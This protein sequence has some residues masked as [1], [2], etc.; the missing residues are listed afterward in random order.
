MA[1]L[2]HTHAALIVL[3]VLVV[4]DATCVIGQLL[5]DIFIVKENLEKTEIEKH[6]LAITL[7]SMFPKF[8]NNTENLSLNEMLGQLK[9]TLEVE[10]ILDNYTQYRQINR[11]DLDPGRSTTALLLN[12]TEVAPQ[13]AKKLPPNSTSAD[14]KSENQN[15]DPSVLDT[16]Q[17]EFLLAW[18][19]LT[20]SLKEDENI[21]K[22]ITGSRTS[23]LG[24]VDEQSGNSSRSKVKES[25]LNKKSSRKTGTKDKGDL[26]KE[27]DI[28]LEVTHVFH[29]ASLSILSILLFETLLKIFAMGRKLWNHKLEVFDA[30][31]II[32]SWS[33]DLAFKDG[34]WDHP[35][36]NAATILI[37]LLPWRVVRIVN[38]FVLVIQEKDN[39]RLKL[40]K[41]RYRSSERRTREYKEKLNKYRVET[42]SLQG[43][44]RKFGVPEGQITACMPIE[45]RK[46]SSLA[47]TAL[48]EFASLAMVSTVGSLPNLASKSE[49]SSDSS[50]S[51]DEES[52]DQHRE[53]DRTVSADSAFSQTD[54]IFSTVSF[55]VDCPNNLGEEN[56]AYIHETLDN[57][58]SLPTYEDAMISVYNSKP[59]E[60]QSQNQH[61]KL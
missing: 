1:K 51:D 36:S 22:L 58:G 38:S 26:E 14:R 60:I 35:G 42:K 29:L 7:Q 8:F 17:D 37:I 13:V 18:K 32:T 4:L 52:S 24:S 5:A 40:I 30:G 6:D 48:S 21:L 11:G 23:Y 45:K 39:V 10:K 31:V 34:I 55:A 53:I 33:L 41:Q 16:E 19:Q 2:L 47:L 57:S 46:R 43:V 3:S 50:S 27:H 12:S 49:F 59:E 15:Q 20:K 25:S 9:E 28:L 44:C 56:I 61:T 54:S